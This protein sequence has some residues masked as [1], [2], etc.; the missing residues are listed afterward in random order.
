MC[1]AIPGLV[2]GRFES[3]GLPMG[4]VDFGKLAREICFSYVPEAQVGDYVIVHV[5]F[6][7]SVLDAEE[8]ART[9]ALLDE[10]GE[11]AA[12]EY[13]GEAPDDGAPKGS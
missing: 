9:L 13:G 2:T 8:A 6:A 1:L 4:T 3:N 5:G 12:A 11:L 7:I 10:L